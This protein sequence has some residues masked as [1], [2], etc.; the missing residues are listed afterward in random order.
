MP[1]GKM[2]TEVKDIMKGEIDVIQLGAASMHELNQVRRNAMRPDMNP[3][4]K[5]LCSVPKVEDELLFGAGVND[6]IKEL[7]EANKV[8]SQ[9]GQGYKRKAQRYRPSRGGYTSTG[10]GQKSGPYQ[11]PQQRRDDRAFGRG[12][13][14]GKRPVRKVSITWKEFV[15]N[16]T[17][18][19]IENTENF[20]AG[21]VRGQ[22]DFW[23]TLTSDKTI[24]TQVLGC[25]IELQNEP[26]Q[27][28]IP[29]PYGFQKGKK[30][31]IEIE[32]QKLLGGN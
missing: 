25:K 9:L 11:R 4:Y 21:Q 14:Q 30:E 26:L 22:F 16:T 18:S 29:Q 24:L 1:K 19:G 5:G 32:V 6:K 23:R 12:Q 27:T 20:Q 13:N 10:R 31:K 8:S 17:A 2:R 28:T 7:S 15:K 3:V